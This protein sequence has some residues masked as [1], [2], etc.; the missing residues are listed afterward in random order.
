[1]EVLFLIG[2]EGYEKDSVERPR[3]ASNLDELNSWVIASLLILAYFLFQ[4]CL[5]P[6]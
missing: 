4:L 2:G 6:S 1:M 5:Y 3:L